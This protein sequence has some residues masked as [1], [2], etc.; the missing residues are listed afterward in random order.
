MFIRTS[1]AAPTATPVEPSSLL[2]LVAGEFAQPVAVQW[3]SP[4][5]AF[6]TAPSARRHLVCLAVLHGADLALVGEAILTQRLRKVLAAVLPRAPSG[7][8]RALERLGD[9]AWPAEGYRQLLGLLGDPPAAK[10]LRHAEIIDL[11]VV[12]RMA[13][14]PGPLAR[15]LGLVTELSPEGVTVLQEAYEALRFRDGEPS[16]RAAA[17]R[18]SRLANAKALSAAVK[19]DLCPE[20]PAPP[21]PGTAQLR[22]MATKAQIRDAARRYENCL[23]DLLPHVASGWSAIY[24]WA[25]TP[26]AIV[27]VTRD[28]IFG[29]RV[30]QVRLAK[31]AAVPETMRQAIATELAAMGMHVGRSGWEL[32]R[33]LFQLTGRVFPMQPIGVVVAEVFG[34]E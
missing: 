23:V 20:P 6:L 8:A 28:H 33:A 34:D 24:E 32:D 16:A 26:S 19:E 13:A 30:E 29:W 3:P 22:P 15:A 21:H 2:K 5:T 12:Q 11:A 9:V 1:G 17:V 7:L 14:L 27:Q 31:N 4:H 25:D 10:V 18:W